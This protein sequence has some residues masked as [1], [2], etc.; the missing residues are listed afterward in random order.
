M[1]YHTSFASNKWNKLEIFVSNICVNLIKRNLNRSFVIAIEY[2][3]KRYNKRVQCIPWQVNM[4]WLLD[5]C[6]N[7]CLFDYRITDRS[8]LR[9]YYLF[10]RL[11][12][13]GISGNIC[14]IIYQSIEIVIHVVSLSWTCTKLALV[15]TNSIFVLLISWILCYIFLVQL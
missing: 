10:S 6:D 11:L 9:Q 14:S 4:L 2:R 5:S 7:H 8:H 12:I 3:N 15:R 13:D 1:T